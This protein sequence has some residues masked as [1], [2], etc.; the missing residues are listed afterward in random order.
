MALFPVTR[1]IPRA[2]PANGWWAR[3]RAS[4]TLAVILSAGVLLV[5]AFAG[6]LVLLGALIVGA[7][8]VA[9]VAR[10]KIGL[11]L[12]VLSVPVQ[13]TVK[14]SGLTATQAAFV[15]L[16]GAWMVGLLLRG[17]RW[18]WL[19]DANLWRFALFYAVI[20]ASARVAGDVRLTL[21]DA[22]RWGEAL[23]IFTIARDVLRTRRDW[24]ALLACCCVG[25]AGE[26]FIGS[27]QSKLG[28]GNASFA[29][30]AGLS[31][32]FGTF[33]R[34]NSYAGY[35]E[36]TFPLALAGTFWAVPRMAEAFRAW[37][38]T[39]RGPLAA[40]RH[41]ARA[42]WGRILA[43]SGLFTTV[44]FLLTG[45]I[46][47]FS[48]GAWLGT[49]AAVL[50]MML[51]AG[52]RMA[53]ATGVVIV[54]AVLVL[55]LGGASVLPDVLAKRLTSVTDNLIV[56]SID[57]TPITDDNFAVKERTAYWFGGLQM[58][59]DN[60]LTGVGLGNYGPNY[61]ARYYSAPFLIS[62]VHAHNYYIHI[63]AETGVFGL[64][65]YLFLIGG[66]IRTGVV[67]SRACTDNFA[68][69][70][71]IGATGVV[72]AVAVHNF[73][74]DLHVLSLGVHLGAVWGVLAAIHARYRYPTARTR[75]HAHGQIPL[76]RHYALPR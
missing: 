45:I 74:E 43:A 38:A 64:L 29:V 67:A 46:L 13:D 10:P 52:R 32:A 73:F 41:A 31:R 39:M 53:R 76:D 23:V 24:A 15:L 75:S 48:R 11:Y 59:R 49:V 72:V 68:R 4:T 14:A 65:A 18:D 42:L 20:L 50:V 22:F 16:M 40:E 36:M 44:A 6:P 57:D 21:S 26:A 62:Q 70:V 3:S 9:V 27:V 37:Q 17:S 34:P 12:A 19:S 47:S 63:A 60:P 51:L 35:L 33:G 28:L 1:S 8:V 61:D 71:A 25:A 54:V 5:L 55:A 58:F 56:T 30:A 66:I 7:V 2:A 69:A